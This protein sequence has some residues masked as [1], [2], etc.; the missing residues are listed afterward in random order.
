M[1][2]VDVISKVAAVRFQ[3]VQY[4]VLTFWP[5]CVALLTEIEPALLDIAIIRFPGK[6]P[7]VPR[8]V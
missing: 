2:E 4:S 1:I 6:G 8:H 7:G 3:S 5:K